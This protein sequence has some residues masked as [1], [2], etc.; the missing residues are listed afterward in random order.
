M[1]YVWAVAVQALG[2]W[3]AWG[4]LAARPCDTDT[5]RKH[6]SFIKAPA[7]QASQ[8]APGRPLFRARAA[9]AAQ[10][11]QAACA[12]PRASAAS[13]PARPLLCARQARAPQAPQA[14]RAPPRAGAAAARARLLFCARAADSSQTARGVVMA[15]S[16]VRPLP[17]GGAPAWRL[18]PPVRTWL[19]STANDQDHTP[20]R[21]LTTLHTKPLALP[22]AQC[23]T[24]TS[25]LGPCGASSMRPGTSTATLNAAHSE[26][27]MK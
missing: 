20:L 11:S 24:P 15:T 27:T 1:S 23:A 17:I 14:A 22:A 2:L 19:L 8:A 10:A 6:G 12:P 18:S 25:A 7:A 3:S 5:G 26:R 21:C 4:A 16:A 13:A 9:R